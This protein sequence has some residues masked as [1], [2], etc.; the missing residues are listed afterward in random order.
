M[1]T[2]LS[3]IKLVVFDLDGTLYDRKQIKGMLIKK[4]LF[5]LR[6]LSKYNK[7]R[8]HAL[9]GCDYNSFADLQSQTA[10]L[11]ANNN[12]A[13]IPVWKNWLA[14]KF[15]PTFYASFPKIKP[16]TGVNELFNH[17]ASCGVKIAVVSDYGKVEDRLKDLKIDS[18]LVDFCWGLE[19][20]GLLKPNVKVGTTLLEKFNLKASQLLFIGDREDTDEQLALDMGAE[21][22]GVYFGNKKSKKSSWNSWEITMKHLL[23]NSF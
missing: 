4:H 2:D 21:F 7:I 3:Q 20:D 17:I 12:G 11:L 13:I 19:E 16:A 8:K 1:I 6:K 22:L 15:Y 5:S 9:V 23:R 18:L 10:T 14:Q